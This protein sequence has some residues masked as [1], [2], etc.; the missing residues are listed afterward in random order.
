MLD[1]ILYVA[2]NSDCHNNVLFF[3]KEFYT[4]TLCVNFTL[5]GQNVDF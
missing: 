3:R 2:D 1:N 5:M 4:Y